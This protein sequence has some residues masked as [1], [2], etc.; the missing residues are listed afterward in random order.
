[1]EEKNRDE[2]IVGVWGLGRKTRRGEETAGGG[3]AR[4]GLPS[5]SLYKCRGAQCP[6]RPILGEERGQG[7]DGKARTPRE[8]RRPV[9]NPHTP[10][11]SP[12]VR[13]PR[14]KKKPAAPLR[15]R[16]GR[17]LRERRRSGYGVRSASV[18]G[19][20]ESHKSGERYTQLAR[21][22]KRF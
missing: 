7:G 6:R 2:N 13:S 1:M 20:G 14:E 12:A 18:S 22:G 16:I 3:L 11:P 9:P 5:F 8:R 4:R 10:S 19:G 21:I 15:D 17:E